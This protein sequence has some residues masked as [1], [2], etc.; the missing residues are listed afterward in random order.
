VEKAQRNNTSLRDKR[1]PFY[2]HGNL[3]QISLPQYL[4]RQITICNYEY[5]TLTGWST[6]YYTVSI[7]SS[8]KV[9]S[10]PEYSE[11]LESTNLLPGS[12][13]PASLWC[14]Y[15]LRCSLLKLHLL[16]KQPK[17]SGGQLLAVSCRRVRTDDHLPLAQR[18]C[19]PIYL[20]ST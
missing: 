16:N 1:P 8:C 6:L 15:M 17:P 9:A 5:S 7:L 12:A 10:G 2:P 13:G 20:N 11:E 3:P 4:L 19:M 14:T 18:D